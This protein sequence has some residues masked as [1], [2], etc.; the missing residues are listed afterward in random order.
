MI[1]VY[2]LQCAKVKEQIQQIERFQSEISKYVV[3]TGCS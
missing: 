2:L 3:Y 1:V